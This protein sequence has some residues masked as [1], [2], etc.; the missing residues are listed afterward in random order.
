[1]ASI[2]VTVAGCGSVSGA[3][4]GDLKQ[5]P[6]VELVSVCDAAPERAARR[7]AEHGVPHEFA[8]VDAM[9]AGPEF[10]LLINL[11]AMPSH[12]PLNLKALQAG[13][14]VL[15]EKPIATTLGEG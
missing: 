14:H 6:H 7:A 13:R 11:T 5:S 2:R 1:M 3:Y 10:D 8:D 4:L 12:F 15:C 9:L